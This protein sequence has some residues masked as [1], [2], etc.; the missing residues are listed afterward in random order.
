MRASWKR[1]AV[2][3]GVLLVTP[4]LASS[5]TITAVWD[6]NP[7]GD[8]VLN[9]EVCVSTTS[10]ACDVTRATVPAGQ[11]SYTF[12]PAPGVLYLVAVR[13]ISAVG[14]GSY[15]AEVRVSIPGFSSLPNRTNATNTL[16]TPVTITARDPDGSTITYSH[17]GLPLGLTLNATTGAISGTPTTAG[18]YNV[19]IL[20]SDGLATTQGSFTWTIQSPSNDTT[21]PS[22]SITSHTSGQTVSTATITLAGTATD[23]GGGA[24]GISNVLVSG[25]AA[26]GGAAT[27]SGTANWSRNVSLATGSNIITVQ[28]IDGVGNS[29]SSTITINRSITPV[30]SVSLVSNVASPRVAGKSITFTATGVGGVT[31]RQYKFLVQQGTAAAQVVQNWSTANTYTWTPGTAGRYTVVVWARSAGVTADAADAS[32][33]MPF[34]V[35]PGLSIT[36]LT[37]TLASPQPANT[38]IGFTAS[39][40]GGTAPYQFKW[41]VFNGT[42]WFVA[43]DWS[44]SAS[45]AWRPS[46]PGSYIVAVWARNAGVTV[47]AS[48]A[49]FQVNYVVTTG[50]TAPL[51]ISS[52]TSSLASPQPANTSISFTA[53]ATGGNAPYQFKWWV[54]NGTAWF[55]MQD[56]STNTSLTWRPWAAGNY[57]VAVWGRNAGVSADASQAMAQVNYVVSTGTSSPTLAVTTLTSSLASPQPPNTSIS[58]TA[59]ASGGT[60]PYQFKWWVYDGTAW[61]VVQNWSTSATLAWRPSASGNYIV[62]VWARNAGVTVDA[63]QAMTQVN[64]VVSSSTVQLKIAGLTSNVATPQPA[65]TAI[66]FTANA[67]GGAAPYQFKWW[68]YNGSGWWVVQDWTSSATLTWRPAT[69]GNY[70]VAVWARNAGVTADASQAMAQVNYAISPGTPMAPMIASL[71]SSL[72]SPQV[73]G[74]SVTF[75]VAA[76]GGAAPYQFKWWVYDGISWTVAQ[77]WSSAT[78]FDWRPTTGGTYLVAVWGRSAGSTL[79]ASEA[80]AQVSYTIGSAASVPPVVTSLTTSANSPRLGVQRRSRHR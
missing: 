74:T 62:A 14:P 32:S 23:S 21:G 29:T 25:A 64:Y 66:S 51:S 59:A 63:S 16:I 73:P 72:A 13:A 53:A 68:V 27:G 37:S 2:V 42:A 46:T 5:Q 1:L 39:A 41:W 15:S 54:F 50:T 34:V 3:I 38:L 18:T 19:T 69:A 71:T 65:N 45:L 26:T 17:T 22:L 57:I 31:P 36:N 8:Q 35:N 6:P 52:L 61:W 75:N 77:N 80:L 67:A 47:D 78:T 10:L 60:G 48:Q 76:N 58:F 20:A 9:Y 4:A 12:S 43:Q 28:A 11:T 79:D 30:T 7:S 44:T 70:I 56:W 49:L 33:Q 24:S 40:A 55:V